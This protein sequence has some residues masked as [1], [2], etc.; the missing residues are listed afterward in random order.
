[1]KISKL[2]GAP[3]ASIHPLA[4]VGVTL[5]DTVVDLSS[6]DCRIIVPTCSVFGRIHV[7]SNTTSWCLSWAIFVVYVAED[8]PIWTRWIVNPSSWFLMFFI[9][10]LNCQK[11][12]G[13]NGKNSEVGLA[14]HGTI[15]L[16]RHCVE[17]NKAACPPM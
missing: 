17:A 13:D 5:T 9:A 16:S 15:A 8:I 3:I 14:T 11:Y 12:C 2:V 6:D 1:M 10:T 7:T 4:L